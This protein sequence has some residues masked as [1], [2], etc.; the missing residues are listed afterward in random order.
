M[1][2]LRVKYDPLATGGMVDVKG[3]KDLKVFKD[4]YLKANDRTW[5]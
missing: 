2:L 4:F 3:F 5:P 1:Y